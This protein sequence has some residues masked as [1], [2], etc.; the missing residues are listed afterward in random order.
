[1]F[2]NE[3]VFNHVVNCYS[4]FIMVCSLAILATSLTARISLPFHIHAKKKNWKKET[5]FT[6]A[7]VQTHNHSNCKVNAQPFNQFMFP[8]NS[9]NCSIIL[10]LIIITYVIKRMHN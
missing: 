9:Y 5:Y 1:M 3:F 10:S 2:Q 6:S 8:D 4:K 7:K